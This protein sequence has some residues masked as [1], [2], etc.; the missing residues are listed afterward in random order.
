[1]LK[2]RIKTLIDLIKNTEIEEIEVSSFWGAQK[3]RLSKNKPSNVPVKI[4]QDS[5]LDDSS[6][7]KVDEDSK[8][9]SKDF[10]KSDA[11]ITKNKSLD[12]NNIEVLDKTESNAEIE[13][14]ID[15]YEMKAP[16]VG[17]FYSS[18]KPSDPPFVNVGDKI[19]KG[20][21]VC[22]IEAMKI[23]NDIESE[24]NGTIHEICVEDG[25]PVEYDQ[26]IIKILPE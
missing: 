17:T 25:S 12:S 20:Q 26:V 16:L 3:I 15:C 7:A 10:D 5:V 14:D 19:T 8:P 22:I 9:L 24:V 6:V 23:F 11:D 4:S 13:E 1:M 21:V 2:N 18:P